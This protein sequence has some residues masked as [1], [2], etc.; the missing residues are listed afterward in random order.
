MP[1]LSASFST[2]SSAFSRAFSLPSECGRSTVI[3][4][5]RWLLQRKV[6]RGATIPADPDEET[7]GDEPCQD[8]ASHDD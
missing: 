7:V 3:L 6:N 1:Y 4:A 5:I 2:S 8:K